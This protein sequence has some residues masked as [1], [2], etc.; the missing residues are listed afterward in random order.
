MSLEV[1]DKLLGIRRLETLLSKTNFLRF[2]IKKIMN[3][4]SY[5]WNYKI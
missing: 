5:E 2:T 1:T 4:V 3:N